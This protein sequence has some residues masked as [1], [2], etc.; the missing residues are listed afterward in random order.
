MH[1][2][3]LDDRV[4]REKRAKRTTKA[5]FSCD[6][7]LV[8][9]CSYSPLWL[10]LRGSMQAVKTRLLCETLNSKEKHQTTVK[11]NLVI[12]CSGKRGSARVKVYCNAN[13]ILFFAEKNVRR[14]FSLYVYTRNT[15]R[16][17]RLHDC[18]FLQLPPFYRFPSFLLPSSSRSLDFFTG[19]CRHLNPHL[20]PREMEHET[21]RYTG[22]F[23]KL[24]RGKRILTNVGL[25]RPRAFL[26]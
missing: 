4:A 5:Y 8:R 19:F 13:T 15:L 7:K 25:N 3:Y 23:K 9:S 17:E 10:L 18:P 26:E 6:R 22:C 20:E 14:R 16:R 2:K 1:R 21:S 24:G 12:F 11:R